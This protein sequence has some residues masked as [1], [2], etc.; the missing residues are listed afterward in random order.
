VVYDRRKKSLAPKKDNNF[1]VQN[2]C[3]IIDKIKQK[4]ICN[5][6][7]EYNNENP[8]DYEWNRS[9]DTML[10]EWDWHSE[11]SKNPIFFEKGHSVNFDMGKGTG[12]TDPV[13]QIGGYL[14]EKVGEKIKNLFQ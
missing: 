14:Y 10:V 2:S 8:G 11:L 6:I 9:V 13:A 12:S 7:I 4:D 5:A 3:H 1:E